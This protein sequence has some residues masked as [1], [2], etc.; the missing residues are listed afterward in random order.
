MH[1]VLI[2]GSATIDV[3]EH[4]GATTL[5]MGGVVTYGGITFRK[6]GLSTTVLCNIAPQDARLR[7][8]LA[9]HGIAVESG[10]T[11][12]SGDVANYA[13]SQVGRV[14]DPTGASDVFFAAYLVRRLHEG[15]SIE[16]SCRHAAEVAAQHVQGKYIPDDCLRLEI[17]SSA[18]TLP[19]QTRVE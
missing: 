14:A 6:H 11:L 12:P 4:S 19:S 5:K 16:A 8:V 2:V 10:V 17:D 9:R 1:H 7:E 13:A 15:Q 18:G 3:I